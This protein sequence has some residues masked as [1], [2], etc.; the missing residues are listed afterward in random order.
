MHITSLQNICALIQKTKQRFKTSYG[1]IILGS[2]IAIGFS[3]ASIIG[4]VPSL[5]YQTA[6]NPFLVSTNRPVGAVCVICVP[7]SFVSRIK[8]SPNNPSS[9]RLPK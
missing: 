2:L 1:L 9:R 5:R 4:H 6:A 7:L 8:T 3:A